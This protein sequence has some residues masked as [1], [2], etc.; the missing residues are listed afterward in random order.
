MWYGCG[1][2]PGDLHTSW[3]ASPQSKLGGGQRRG[4]GV[5]IQGSHGEANQASPGQDP[6]SL[7]L[8]SHTQD[9]GEGRHF[10]TRTGSG[11]P[12]ELWT[13]PQSPG[14][15]RPSPALHMPKTTPGEKQADN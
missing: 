5:H 14:T 7:V 8:Y 11:S 9:Q 13:P 12:Q 4:A 2:G 15:I 10:S 6:L 3:D 1:A